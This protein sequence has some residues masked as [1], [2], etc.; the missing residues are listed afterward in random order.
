MRLR[1]S[2]M[3]VMLLCASLAE[4]Q[5]R[6]GVFGESQEVT[7]FPIQPPAVLLP[8]GSVEVSVRNLS[9]AS[10]RIVERLRE[11]L[12]RQLTG[13]DTRLTLA[14]TNAD[15]IVVATLTEWSEGRRNSTKYVSET[16][17]IGTREVKDKDG[18]TKT[19]PVYEYGRNRPSVVING[20][21]GVRL[22]VRRSA[23][24]SPIADETARHSVREEHLLDASPPSRDAVEDQLLDNVVKKAAGQI[25]PGRVPVRVLLARS[26]EVDPLNALAQN[27]RWNDWLKELQT[28]K[29]NRDRKRDAYRIHNLAVAHESLAYEASTPE[30]AIEALTHASQLIGQS[31]Q[32]NGDEKY[33]AES[34]ERIVKSSAAYRRLATLHAQLTDAPPPRSAPPGPNPQ[35]GHGAGAGKT[36]APDKAPSAAALTNKDV[37]DLVV[38][39]LDDENLIATINE[40]RTVSFDLTPAGL[41]TLLAGKVSNRVINAMRARGK[42][43]A[44][45]KE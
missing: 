24:G 25:S 26:T 12:A 4:A 19:E 29:P 13:N 32:M 41:K 35:P 22:E 15:V 14:E 6:R 34:A 27:R 23:G 33:I 43:S 17:Q 39:G 30:E 20:A 37:I 11:S 8:A 7:L 42:S 31:A 10:A 16:R 21:A 38:A 9:G 40:A 28:V 5:F 18:K 36:P 3:A 44:P 45:I 1:L 2:T